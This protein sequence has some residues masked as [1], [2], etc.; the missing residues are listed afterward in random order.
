MFSEMTNLGSS[1]SNLR[2][3]QKFQKDALIDDL[4]ALSLRE[5]TTFQ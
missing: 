3:K 4:L 1:A 2:E 5:E